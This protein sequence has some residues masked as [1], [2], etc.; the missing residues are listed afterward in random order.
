MPRCAHVHTGN[1]WL[2]G[3]ESWLVTPDP[4][5]PHLHW[6]HLPEEP[7]NLLLTLSA[8]QLCLWVLM[9]RPL[10]GPGS[11]VFFSLLLCK[12]LT[13]PGSQHGRWLVFTCADFW[14]PRGG[15]CTYPRGQLARGAGW[16]MPVG[17]LL[18]SG[19]SGLSVGKHACPLCGLLHRAAP[20]LDPWHPLPGGRAS[21][22]PKWPRTLPYPS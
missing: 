4:Q 15:S 9:T 11:D 19:R 2:R 16:L 22:G 8:S 10:R 7:E 17:S 1:R 3:V 20:D 18:S 12:H 13:H 14:F 21:V 6:R 5:A